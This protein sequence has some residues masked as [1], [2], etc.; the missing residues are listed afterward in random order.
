MRIRIQD[1]NLYIMLVFTY[2]LL[3]KHSHNNG[4]AMRCSSAGWLATSEDECIDL[5]TRTA[6]PSHNHPEGIKGRCGNGSGYQ[7]C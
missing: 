4:S 6:M 5:A 1:Y 3:C 7:L 2:P